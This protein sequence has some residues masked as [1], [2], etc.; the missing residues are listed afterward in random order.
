[1]VW[2][3]AAVPPGGFARGEAQILFHV[4]GDDPAARPGAAYA[5]EADARLGR[6]PPGVRRGE[7]SAAGPG[8][9]VE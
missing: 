1:M 7:E 6:H 9:A 5:G 3:G 2:N 8:R 4:L